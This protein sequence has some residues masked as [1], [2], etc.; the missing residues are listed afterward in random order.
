MIGSTPGEIV[1]DER[2]AALPLLALILLV[3]LGSAAMAIDLGWL[4]WQSIEIQHGADAA[5]LA[6][7]V[8]EPDQRLQAHTVATASA[9]QNG[10]DEAA[11]STTVA[12]V[13]FGDDPAAVQTDGMLR[14]TITHKV[15]TFFMK[16]FGL[17]DFDIKRTALAE[18][19][20]PLALGSPEQTFGNDPATG[21]EP[22]F[23]ANINGTY[24][25]KAGGNRYSSACLNDEEDD[26]C[27]PNPEWRA[28]SGWGTA[29]ALGGYLYGIEVEEGSSAG[30]EVEIFNGPIYAIYKNKDAPPPATGTG[31]FAGDVKRNDGWTVNAV[32]WFMLYGPDPTPYDSTDGNELLCSVAYDARVST[33]PGDSPP[34]SDAYAGDFPGWNNGWLEF[35]QVPQGILNDMWDNMAA[36]EEGIAY[37]GCG[38]GFDRGPGIYL[39]RVLNQ[40]DPVG[41]WHASN[42]YSLRVSSAGP[43]QPTI[44][45]IGDMAMTA[46]RNTPTTEFFLA[47][48]EER[49]AGKDM[50]IELWD[51]G[52]IKGP[53]S[54]SFTILTGTGAGLDCDWVATSTTPPSNKTSGSGPCTINASAKKFNNELITI[55]VEIEDDYTCSGDACWFRIR[56]DYVGL[57]KD[58]TTWTAYITGNPI[59]LV[60]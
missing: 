32:T 48:V 3:L 39:L 11:A 50:T 4:F 37:G 16:A 24:E 2:G 10:F 30:L 55:T 33:A 6:G 41:D 51:V 14:V 43:V 23:W 17:D 20:L 26:P 29:D 49:Y 1:A 21:N 28:S 45:G 58:T 12:V 46:A 52:D 60:E 9:L 53:G 47:R 31:N 13:D 22:G 19:V 7:V 5:A 56:Y 34:S 38:A 8:Y 42:N 18:Y 25:A 15:P 35:D 57:V 44:A 36:T 27:T 54:D 40:Q 59:R